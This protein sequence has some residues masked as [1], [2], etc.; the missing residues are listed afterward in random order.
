[1]TFVPFKFQKFEIKCL[2]H[3]Y[4]TFLVNEE[5]HFRFDLK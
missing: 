4:K 5:I 3:T 1:M 2:R